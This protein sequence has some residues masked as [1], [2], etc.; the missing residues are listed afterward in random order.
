M[1]TDGSQTAAGVGSGILLTDNENWQNKNTIIPVCTIL[2]LIQ[3]QWYW[4]GV[5]IPAIIWYWSV[6]IPKA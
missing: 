5:T 2:R 4:S 6:Q 3:P 1:Y